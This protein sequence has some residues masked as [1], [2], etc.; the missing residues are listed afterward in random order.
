MKNFI[1]T[2]LS[3]ILVIVVG[4]DIYLVHRHHN[5]KEPPSL[6]VVPYEHFYMPQEHIESHFTKSEI[7]IML[8]EIYNVD[9][10]YQE[11]K[12]E[13][14]LVGGYTENGTIYVDKKASAIE[15]IIILSHELTHIKYNTP[16]ETFTEYTSIVKL[17]ESSNTLFQKVA[18]NRA[19]F[20]V[21]GGL[22]GLESDCGYYLIKYFCW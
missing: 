2:T 16:N 7:K 18:L 8:D 22:A 5:K 15:Y 1:L 19:K 9:Y 6:A 20:I 4:F 17:Y 11:I 12:P 21:S 3:T 10:D 14:T 13:N